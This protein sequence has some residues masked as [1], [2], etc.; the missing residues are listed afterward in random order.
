[1]SKY[2]MSLNVLAKNIN[3]TSLKGGAKLGSVEKIHFK[4]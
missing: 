4:A 1:M 3:S 2:L